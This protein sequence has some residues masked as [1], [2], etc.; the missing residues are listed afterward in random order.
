[1]TTFKSETAY[2]SQISSDIDLQNLK[3]SLPYLTM[4]A[5]LVV[6]LQKNYKE[7]KVNPKVK[8]YNL[9]IYSATSDKGPFQ[10]LEDNGWDTKKALE[11]VCSGKVDQ[12]I[13]KMRGTERHY[14]EKEDIKCDF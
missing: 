1:M 5:T 11:K 7:S 10:Y 2:N 4:H 6:V 12:P 13:I 8:K 9:K 3:G 14:L